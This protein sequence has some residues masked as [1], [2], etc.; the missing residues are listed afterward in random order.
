MWTKPRDPWKN[1]GVGDS[2]SNPRSLLISQ[3]GFFMHALF[4]LWWSYFDL[5]SKP[6]KVQCFAGIASI[7]YTP[8]PALANFRI[9]VHGWMPSPLM[10]ARCCRLRHVIKWTIAHLWQGY[11]NSSF[12]FV[13]FILNWKNTIGLYHGT[14]K[15]RWNLGEGSVR[16]ND[17][18]IHPTPLGIKYF[19]VAQ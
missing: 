1:F 12:I 9:A 3:P 17:Q 15:H 14:I 11:W 8:T 4:T 6:G 19:G 13:Q 2:I 5:N 16:T 7:F 10:I 18:F